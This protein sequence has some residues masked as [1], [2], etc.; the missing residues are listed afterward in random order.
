L[1]AARKKVYT[2]AIESTA[3]KK[4]VRRIAPKAVAQPVKRIAPKVAAQPVKRVVRKVSA[5]PF[6]RI[7]PIASAQPIPKLKIFSLAVIAVLVFTACVA[8]SRFAQISRNHGQIIS[9]ERDL[10]Q[11]QDTAE[12]LELELTERK[13]LRRIE[14]I[15]ATEIGMKYPDETQV[16]FVVLP[17]VFDD[18]PKGLSEIQLTAEAD[19]SIWERISRRLNHD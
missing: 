11:K 13:D 1:L 4:H 17:E 3:R 15:A 19:N 14:K 16:Q 8:I 7:V 10:Q 12:L 9:L 18:E 2:D 6:K 5:Q